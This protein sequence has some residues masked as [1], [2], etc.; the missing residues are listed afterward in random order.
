M[1]P[2]LSKS[3]VAVSVLY[4]K[5][6][7]VGQQLS[8]ISAPT[9]LIVDHTGTIVAQ[10]WLGDDMILWDALESENISDGTH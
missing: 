7:S 10:G 8:L 4:D 3:G 6:D 5:E 2:K 1:E 9:N